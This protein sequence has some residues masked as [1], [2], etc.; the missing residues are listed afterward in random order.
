M[1]QFVMECDIACFSALGVKIDKTGECVV[2]NTGASNALLNCVYHFNEDDPRIEINAKQI[3]DEFNARSLPHCWWTETASE[4]P[5]LKEI[6]LTHHKK[7][8]GE[9]LGMGIDVPHIRRESDAYDLK[10]SMVSTESDFKAWGCIIAEGYEFNESDKDFY[11][12]L[13]ARAGTNGPFYHL[14]GKKNG[15]VVSTGTVLCT[16]Q[17]AYLYNIATDNAEQRK[18]YGSTITNAL[19]DITKQK[20]QKRVALVSTVAAASIYRRLGFEEFCRFHIF[21]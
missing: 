6:L 16:E 5:Q 12:S 3:L 20:N 7:L 2:S 15:K 11:T 1:K 10:I 8:Y 21:I 17:G 18:G 9:F 13:F 4:P 19:L 14:I